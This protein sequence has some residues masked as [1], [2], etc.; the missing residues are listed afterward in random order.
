MVSKDSGKTI[1]QQSFLQCVQRNGTWLDI[2]KDT[3]LS[4]LKKHET[5]TPNATRTDILSIQMDVE[6]AK[7][8]SIYVVR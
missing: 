7:Y 5:G 3:V 4:F 8:A 2:G 6:F 1:N